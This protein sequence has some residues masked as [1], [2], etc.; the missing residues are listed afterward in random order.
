[1]PEK[2]CNKCGVS[3]EINKHYWYPSAKAKTGFKLSLCR[4]CQKQYWIEAHRKASGK[5]EPAILAPNTPFD[6]RCAKQRVRRL[7]EKAPSVYQE[8]GKRSKA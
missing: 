4:P 6:E 8:T 7:L 1:M 2:K 5:Y 3:K